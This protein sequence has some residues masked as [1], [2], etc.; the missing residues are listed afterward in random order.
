MKIALAQLNYHVGN[1]KANTDKIIAAIADAEKQNADLIVFSELC[2]SGYPAR[3]FLEF[4]DFISQCENAIAEI[5]KHTQQVAVLIGCPRKNPVK[6]GK[7]L[8]NSAFFIYSGEV[9]HIT[10]KALLPTY[11]IFDEYRYFEPATEFVNLNLSGDSTPEMA[12]T[13][14]YSGTLTAADFIL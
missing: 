8:F 9:K 2:I 13:V 6:E 14:Q 5:A 1:F 11:D 4:D 12:F 7:D 3:D 10:N